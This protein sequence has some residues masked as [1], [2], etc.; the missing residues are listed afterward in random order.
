M[1]LLVIKVELQ[2]MDMAE[3]KVGPPLVDCGAMGSFLS[4]NYVEHNQL[5]TC[6]L[7]FPIPVYNMDGSPNESGSITEIVDVILHFDSHSERTTFAVTN[8]RRQDIILGLTWLEEHNLE[9]N[10]QTQKVSMSC[11]PIKCHMCQAELQEEQKAF[12]KSVKDIQT[13]RAGPTPTF[14]EDKSEFALDSETLYPESTL[15]LEALNLGSEMIHV[16]QTTSQRLAEAHQKS[17]PTEVVVPKYFQGFM[18][19]FAKELFDALPNQKV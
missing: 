15:D 9:I 13:C 7:S 4:R 14:L 12:Q 8:L 16:S 1:K 19:V 2:T 10:W 3:V 17:L 11:C 5:T 6:K 18:D